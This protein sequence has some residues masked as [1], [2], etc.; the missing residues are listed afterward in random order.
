MPNPFV[1]RLKIYSAIAGSRLP[2]SRR[3]L[4]ARFDVSCKTVGRDLLDLAE[5]GFPLRIDVD[6]SGTTIYSLD[7]ERSLPPGFECA[8]CAAGERDR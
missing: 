6:R 7:S 1:R 2:K 3:Q 5:A 4:A 8:R